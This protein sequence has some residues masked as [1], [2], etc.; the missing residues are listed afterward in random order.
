MPRATLVLLGIGLSCSVGLMLIA[1]AVLGRTVD[2][3]FV[4]GT[5]DRL[6]VAA[7][8]P[9]VLICVPRQI[10]QGE[11]GRLRRPI[12]RAVGFIAIVGPLWAVL[13]PWISRY[14]IGLA[15]VSVGLLVPTVSAMVLQVM[16]EELLFRVLLPLL[17]VRMFGRSPHAAVAAT[18]VAALL[19]GLF[20]APTSPTQ[21]LDHVLF[22]VLMHWALAATRTIK[23][24]IILHVANNIYAHAFIADPATPESSPLLLASKF[25][26]LFAVAA[27]IF[28]AR[29]PWPAAAWT[30]RFAAPRLAP[31]GEPTPPRSVLVDVLRGL[32]LLY[33]MLENLLAFLPAEDGMRAASN[34]D[35]VTRA[36]MALLVEYRGLPLFALLLGFGVYVL[37]QHATTPQRQSIVTRRNVAF[38]VLGTVHGLLI[39][40]GDILAV[41]GL[42][43]YA[44]IW[45]V[46]TR[47]R[48]QIMTWFSGGLFLLQTLVLPFTLLATAEEGVEGAATSMLAVTATEAFTLRPTEWLLYVLSTPLLSSGLLFPMLIGYRT[49]SAVLSRHPAPRAWR[50]LAI[51]SGVLS[52][53]LCWPY[54]SVLWSSWGN[55]VAV[56]GH[57]WRLVAA[58]LGGLCGAMAAWATVIAIRARPVGRGRVTGQLA[59]LGRRSLTLYLL[60]SLVYLVLLTPPYG[61]LSMVAPLTVLIPIVLVACAGAGV[62]LGRASVARA[63]LAERF[64]RDMAVDPA[65][66]ESQRE[67]HG[68]A[69]ARQGATESQCIQLTT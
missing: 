8:L 66:S 41:Y 6:A 31:T 43:M 47:R 68:E 67:G 12:I 49:A 18:V 38:I 24:P 32:A 65:S 25:L 50:T 48:A 62:V 30:Q 4:G 45:A 56:A 61:G 34:P 69:P 21:F 5:V 16:T 23:V 2:D 7:M 19:F 15:P 59:L 55:S 33:I 36:A 64:I 26:I 13:V 17:L 46:R 14:E 37:M 10:P 51:G 9:F 1:E 11:G 52:I 20:H 35:R 3:Q 39:F 28:P 63:G 27:M 60:H 58:Q 29:T 57:P 40:S 54:A 53:V 42:L 22:A 44:L